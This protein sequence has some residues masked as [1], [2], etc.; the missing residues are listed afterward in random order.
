MFVKTKNEKKM[1]KIEKIIF[2][3]LAMA[4]VACGGGEKSSDKK[5]LT[6][7]VKV[8][9]S[10]TVYPITEAVAEAALLASPPNI[11]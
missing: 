3:I 10:S 5:G 7:N 4:L 11:S 6:G 1:K 8:D 9:G 2:G